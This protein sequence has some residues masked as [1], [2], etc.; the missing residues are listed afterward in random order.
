MQADEKAAMNIQPAPKKATPATPAVRDDAVAGDGG[1]G[2]AGTGRKRGGG[3]GGG[4][5][6]DVPPAAPLV[7][8][9][10]APAVIKTGLLARP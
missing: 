6:A 5:S 1:G 10:K 9:V 3:K 2:G 4:S 8:P 7:P